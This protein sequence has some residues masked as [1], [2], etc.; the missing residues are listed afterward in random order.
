MARD[1]FWFRW[2]PLKWLS[3]TRTVS[4]EGR[5]AYAD[6]ISIMRE[7][8]GSLPDE[9]TDEGVEWHVRM[10]AVRDARTVRRVVGELLK[11]GKLKRLE[12]GRLT[13]ARVEEDMRRREGGGGAGGKGG[14]GKAPPEAPLLRAIEGGRSAQA[15]V[16]NPVEEPGQVGEMPDSRPTVGRQTVDSR[17]SR[18]EFLNLFKGRRFSEEKSREDHEFAAALMA[19]PRA[20]G[21]P[22][23]PLA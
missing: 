13:N 17:P 23:R 10:L 14:A 19:P 18:V 22:G 6:Y 3:G 15:P 16:G 4:L 12:D 21:D 20:R 11:K 9:R 1:D 7:G 8:D 2:L 5:G